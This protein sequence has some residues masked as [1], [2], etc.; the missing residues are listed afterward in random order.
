MDVVRN[1]L[2]KKII[3]AYETSQNSYDLTGNKNGA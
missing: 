2:V 3:Q 1:P